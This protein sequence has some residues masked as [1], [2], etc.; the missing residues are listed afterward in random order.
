MSDLS[1]TQAKETGRGEYVVMGVAGA[2]KSTVARMLAE[3][4]GGVFLEGDDSHPAANKAKMA[5][6][7]PLQDADRWEWLDRLNA[8]L[9]ARAGGRPV[10]LAC[11]ALR[12]A[13]RERL[14][15]GLPGLR[16]IFLKG[17]YD[18]IR[19]R[20]GARQGHFMPASLLESQF[21]TLEVPRGGIEADVG[22]PLEE[23]VD[24]VLAQL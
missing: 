4:T 18:L 15:A 22:K 19:Q 6:G 11:S 5:A 2:G 10:F 7:I 16:F 24:S 3:R 8:E 14:A 12:E 23:I 1:T 20:L 13:Y 21:E 17:S 9:K